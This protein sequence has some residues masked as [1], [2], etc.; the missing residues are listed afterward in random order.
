MN[1]S[2]RHDFSLWRI[3]SF[4]GCLAVV[5]T[6]Y[7]LERV[8]FLIANWRVFAKESTQ[9]LLLAFLQGVRFDSAFVLLFSAPFLLLTLF[10]FPR[11]WRARDTL[12]RWFLV[13][14][15]AVHAP[16]LIINLA[17]AH[18]YPFSG[19][20]S[21]L[22]VLGLG[23]D[24]ADQA[25]QLLV[26]YWFVPIVAM[27]ALVAVFLIMRW[28]VHVRIP[29][30]V[31]WKT[32]G[33]I[34]FL[35][36]AATVL[37]IR[38][39]L[40][41]KPLRP[42]HAYVF[43]SVTLGDLALNTPYVV[44]RTKAR[45]SVPMLNILPSQAEVE[46][47]TGRGHELVPHFP[48]SRDNVVLIILESFGLEFM[49]GPNQR[50]SQIPFFESLAARGLF[51]ANNYANG[52][53]SIE[54]LPSILA[55]IPSL[56][57][58]PYVTSRYVGNRLHGLG[59][60]LSE[61]GYRTM[62]FHGGKNG[63]MHF[64]LMARLCGF[65]EYFGMAEYPDGNDFDGAWGIYDGPFLQFM[66]RRLDSTPEP[67]AAAVFTLSS[68]NP[69]PVP[70]EFARTAAPGLSPFQRALAYSDQ[71]LADFFR[72]AEKAP[73]FKNTLF[74]LTADHTAEST[75]AAY[76]TDDGQFRVPLVFFHGG[77]RIAPRESPRVTQH[78]DVFPSTLDFLGIGS[79]D[80]AFPMLPFGRSVFA[81]E[82]PGL[83]I[84][85]VSGSYWLKRDGAEASFRL[86][87]GSLA[88]DQNLGKT[89]QAFIQLFNNG[90]NENSWY[91]SRREGG[92]P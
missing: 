1:S 5:L 79:R 6:A 90:I 78:A 54:A 45:E 56:M 48:P 8:E 47:L 88:G 16:W 14:F 57:D 62:F 53:R 30:R 70:E 83:A 4:L 31:S 50:A 52:R 39:G 68:H 82:R 58:E 33:G 55:G 37:G 87:D 60:V 86:A 75:D 61:R 73:W 69:F 74:V 13:A 7:T 15:F 24:I 12:P 71:S 38:G 42:T 91:S 3:L 29:W 72:E 9:E 49:G 85:Q 25:T 21:N 44:V 46:R 11:S 35:A 67:F 10:P 77:G 34:S 20:R 51:F 65:E 81:E 26:Q 2:D 89:L 41:T 66:R 17:D 84:N 40:Q 36:L 63:T 23:E 32:W 76:R 18:Y 43:S 64:D 28:L 19:R 59:E 27:A 22:S 92:S 80:L